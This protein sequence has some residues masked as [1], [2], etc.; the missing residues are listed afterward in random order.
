MI[1][2]LKESVKNIQN[3]CSSIKEVYKKLLGTIV[4]AITIL[5]IGITII[6]SF[7]IGMRGDPI[8]AYLAATGV[9]NPSNEI[10]QQMR[11]QLGFCSPTIIRYFRFVGDLFT[12]NWKISVSIAPNQP[13]Y[14]LIRERLPFSIDLSILP[15]I[16][17]I[18]VG[19]MLGI[20]SSRHRGK[21]IDRFIQILTALGISLPFFLLVSRFEPTGY[22]SVEF[23][24]PPFVTGSL[25]FDSILSGQQYLIDD[26]LLHMV[27]P[28]LS[29][30]IFMPALITR[31]TRSFLKKKSH[32][33]SISSITAITGAIFG[34]IFISVVLIEVLF[35]L[36]GF[37]QLFIDAFLL[38]DYFM[39]ITVL[40]II[41]LVFVIV[42]LCSN[43]LFILYRVLINKGHF[44]RILKLKYNRSTYEEEKLEN[45][46]VKTEHEGSFK[47][48]LISRLK[49]PIFFLSMILVLFFIFV[50]K[51][52]QVFT[53]YSFQEVM[54]PQAGSWAPPSPAHP[55]GQ[56]FM[57]GDVLGRLMWGIR[58]SML[59]GISVVFIGLIGGA[60]FGL[61]AGKFNIL[62][63]RIIMGFMIFFYVFPVLVLVLLPLGLLGPFAFIGLPII[64]SL[65]PLTFISLPIIGILLIPN[66]TRTIAD[67]ILD[68]VN[69]KGIGKA[70]IRSIPLNLSIAILIYASIGF[71]GF[72]LDNQVI[73]GTDISQGRVNLS[74]APWASFW[75]SLAVFGMVFSFLLLNIGLQDYISKKR[76]LEN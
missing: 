58:D 56:T 71:L 40:F 37:G 24:N 3:R 48:Y 39:I 70:I 15:M 1:P 36:N 41:L 10:Y 32:K 18:S 66:F 21:K 26:Y 28:V 29:F 8:A 20:I 31:K 43:L 38:Y 45:E 9:H 53:Q 7:T 49:S 27:L 72:F 11:C 17:G 74:Q 51:F 2:N 68:E 4:L 65:G 73:L 63:Y 35:G 46:N 13:V 16:I 30:S 44:K 5:S 22:L 54:T 61:I 69:Y 52:P 47:E 25:I 14:D 67:S 64:G 76:P 42:T 75:P 50:S 55:L 60:I 33:N 6:F 59:F 19:I 57:G 23:T 34:Y 12:G 62:G